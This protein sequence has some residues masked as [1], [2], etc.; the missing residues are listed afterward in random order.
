[1]LV[2]S[3]GAGAEAGAAAVLLADLLQHRRALRADL[4]AV[5][6]VLDA[7]VVVVLRRGEVV[8][9]L[10]GVRGRRGLVVRVDRLVDLRQPARTFRLQLAGQVG[11][12]GQE[13]PL[14]RAA[15]RP[16]G[17]GEGAGPA[18]GLLGQLLRVGEHLPGQATDERGRLGDHRGPVVAGLGVQLA[19]PVGGG[20]VVLVQRRR[21]E[22]G[23]HRL[24][25]EVQLPVLRGGGADPGVEDVERGHRLRDLVTAPGLGDRLEQA[26]SA[27]HGSS[28][29]KSA[30]NLL[31]AGGRSGRTDGNGMV[32]DVGGA[33]I[34][35]A[36]AAALAL[37]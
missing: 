21:G 22:P 11:G 37:A 19:Q 7:A 29:S 16:V 25:R 24:G 27:G 15:L 35:A 5:V 28:R 3:L 34:V 31:R 14:G 33:V 23:L 2:G 10:G 4:A 30:L 36:R 1:M 26:G 9:H 12:E 13:L 18:V 8:K 20:R 17:A 32:T 6:L